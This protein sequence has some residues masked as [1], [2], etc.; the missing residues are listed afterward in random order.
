MPIKKETKSAGL[1]VEQL[2]QS[3]ITLK[4][5][6]TGPLVYNSMSLKAMS[7]LIMGAAKKTAAQKKDIKHNPEEEFVDSCDVNGQKGAFLSFPSTGIKK[8]MAAS[9]LETEGVTK[10]GINRGIDG[11]GEH[12]NICGKS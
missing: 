11:G 4:I 5:V 9:A 12:L 2:K 6:G 10:A 1:T 7:T 3:E 8:G